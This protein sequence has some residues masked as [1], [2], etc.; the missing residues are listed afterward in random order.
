MTA[1]GEVGSPTGLPRGS[2]GGMLKRT[3]SGP[4]YSGVQLPGAQGLRTPERE[5]A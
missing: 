3:M 1:N 5:P 2:W 4:G